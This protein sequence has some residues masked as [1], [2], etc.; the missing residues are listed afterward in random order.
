MTDERKQKTKRIVL[1]IIVAAILVAILALLL[2]FTVGGSSLSSSGSSG[3]SGGSS[4]GGGSD[5]KIYF[6]LQHTTVAYCPKNIQIGETVSVVLQADPGYYFLTEDI[7]EDNNG[8]W[9]IR[10]T[11]E[12][13]VSGCEYFTE[14][15]EQ[16][17]TGVDRFDDEYGYSGVTYEYISVTLINV[18]RYVT[19]SRTLETGESFHVRCSSSGYVDGKNDAFQYV[20]YNYSWKGGDSSKG[21]IAMLVL[22]ADDGCS[23]E[24]WNIHA[25]AD[26]QEDIANTRWQYNYSFSQDNKICRVWIYNID[27]DIVVYCRAFRDD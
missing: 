23:F 5:V 12:V 10:S 3:S 17:Q 4:G 6:A 1:W 16:G 24:T 9:D 27:Q 14:A 21:K 22:E 25:C 8:E 15:L 13:S 2:H 11:H 18:P 7:D 26:H 19:V 20:H